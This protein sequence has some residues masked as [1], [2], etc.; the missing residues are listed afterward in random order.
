MLCDH[1]LSAAP[2]QPYQRPSRTFIRVGVL[3]STSA[4]AMPRAWLSVQLR[5]GTWQV[6]QEN[7]PSAGQAGIEEQ[8]L[9]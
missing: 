1:R 8:A 3:R 6:P 7:L 9:A 5:S 4:A 2:S